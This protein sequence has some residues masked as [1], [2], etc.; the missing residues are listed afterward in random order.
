M[1]GD[2]LEIVGASFEFAAVVFGGLALE[3]AEPVRKFI[4]R[5]AAALG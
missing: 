2:T 3:E 4:T 5:T 1:S